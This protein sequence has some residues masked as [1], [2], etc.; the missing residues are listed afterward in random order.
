MELTDQP[1]IETPTTWGNRLATDAA[2]AR[3]GLT[4]KIAYEIG[5]A[6]SL[7]S[8]VKHG[9]GIAIGPMSFINPEDGI[10]A[11]PL[12]SDAPSLALSL[13]VPAGHA[14]S[15]PT[16]ALLQTAREL[17]GAEIAPPSSG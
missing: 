16:K 2:F 9:L 13:A 15:A 6:A 4:R 8:L 14:L 17:S 7:A 10:R 11:V 5:D 12:G 1:F 3:A